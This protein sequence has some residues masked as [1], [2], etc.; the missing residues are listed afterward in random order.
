M[1]VKSSILSNLSDAENFSDAKV[2][3]LM[4]INQWI[5]DDGREYAC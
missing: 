5:F 3:C 2:S 1:R 4:K